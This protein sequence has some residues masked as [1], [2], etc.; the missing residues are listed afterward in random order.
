MTTLIKRS[1]KQLSIDRNQI[2][3]AVDRKTVRQTE[4]KL[5]KNE[6]RSS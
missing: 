4:L 5:L 2:R 3:K 1:L 6:N